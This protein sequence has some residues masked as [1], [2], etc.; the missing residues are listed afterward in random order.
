MVTQNVCGICARLGNTCCQETEIYL[1]M[2]D[3]KRIAS[4]VSRLDFFEY[5]K[6]LDPSYLDQD[7]DPVWAVQTIHRD[8]TRRVL[9]KKNEKDCL[10]L[11][12]IGCQL[13]MEV[14]PLVCRLHPLTYT[15]DGLAEVLDQR[16]LSVLPEP[17]GALI[18]AMGMNPERAMVWHRQLYQEI[19]DQE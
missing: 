10:F 2:G 7:D 11:T 12:E 16:C 13:S 8:G 1:T 9:K 18:T 4:Q 17:A 5:R 6:P 19:F 15:M 14:R 3:V